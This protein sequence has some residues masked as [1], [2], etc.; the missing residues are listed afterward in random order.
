M[1]AYFS[2]QQISISFSLLKWQKMKKALNAQ[3]ELFQSLRQKISPSLNSIS[4]LPGNWQ[5]KRSLLWIR[6]K[7]QLSERAL[8]GSIPTNNVCVRFEAFLCS[9]HEIK[10]K[11]KCIFIFTCQAFVFSVNT[12]KEKG[13]EFFAVWRVAFLRQKKKKKSRKQPWCNPMAIWLV[14]KV[15]QTTEIP[16]EKPE[17][18]WWQKQS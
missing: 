16:L 6:T 2:F 9:F 14:V 3:W 11:I 12:S 10:K 4:S 13:F 15:E 18:H 17:W 7:Y 5:Q 1:D 8:D